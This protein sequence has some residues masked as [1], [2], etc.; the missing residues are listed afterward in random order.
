LIF[1][2]SKR[3]LHA[4]REDRAHF[5]CQE[6]IVSFQTTSRENSKSNFCGGESFVALFARAIDTRREWRYLLKPLF[7]PWGF[8]CVSS[9]LR[10]LLS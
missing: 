1:V 6:N 5:L 10:Q 4:D 8:A 9:P 7:R 3:K 2:I